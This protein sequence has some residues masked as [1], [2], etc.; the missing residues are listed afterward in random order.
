MAG[1]ALLGLMLL[2]GYNWQALFYAVS[3]A[4]VAQSM[5]LFAL[6]PADS[7]YSLSPATEDDSDNEVGCATS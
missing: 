6:V 3:V 1:G 7:P 2:K 5:I 4:A